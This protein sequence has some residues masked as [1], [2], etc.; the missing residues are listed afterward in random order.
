ML[1][2][3]AYVWVWTSALLVHGGGGCCGWRG[4]LSLLALVVPLLVMAD[5]VAPRHRRIG[6]IVVV[7]R[8]V[9]MVAAGGRAQLLESI[10]AVRIVLVQGAIARVPRDEAAHRQV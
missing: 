3:F 10:E 8:G 2:H 6:R 5:A 7:L 1:A 4:S 9:A